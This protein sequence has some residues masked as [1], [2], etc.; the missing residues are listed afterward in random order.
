M[1][2]DIDD[3]DPVELPIDG[4]L[5]LHTFRPREIKDLVVDYLGECRKKG[6]LDVRIIHGKG[7]GSLRRTVHSVLNKETGVY[8]YRLAEV[9]RGS[10]GATIVRLR[11]LISDSAFLVNES[12]ARNVALSRDRFARLWVTDSTRRLWEDFSRAVYPLDDVELPLRNR[13]YLGVLDAALRRDPRTVFLNL[14]AGFTS[15]PFLVETLPRAIEVDFEHVCNFK[16]SKIA[17]WQ[18]KGLMPP[19]EIEFMPCDLSSEC[20]LDSLASRLGEILPA[21]TSVVFLEGITYYLRAARLERILGILANA[22]RPRSIVALDFWTPDVEQHPVHLRLRRFFAER[23]GH[24]ESDY[25]LFERDTFR[26]VDGYDLVE[27]CDIAELEKRFSSDQKLA[28][29][30]EIIPECYAVLEHR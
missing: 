8:S 21:A 29:P 5:D 13:F 6:I 4:I 9:Q 20:D 27:M 11:P 12:R 18:E 16:R 30:L 24:A 10:W 2:D 28:D 22:Q 1:I 7:T 17:E 14:A 19:R 26:S 15:Y 25:S 23:F 3:L